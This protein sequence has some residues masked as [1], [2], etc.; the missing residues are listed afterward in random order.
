WY[1]SDPTLV[2]KTQRST[3]VLSDT[4]V[5]PTMEQDYYFSYQRPADNCEIVGKTNVLLTNTLCCQADAG[6]IILPIGYNSGDTLFQGENLQSFT[7]DYSAI[8][9]VNPD[10]TK[11]QYTFL[12]VDSNSTIIQQTMGDFDFTD[13]P[14]GN[15]NVYGLSYANSNTPSNLNNYV[16]LIRNDVD[17]NDITQI[18][19]NENSLA[20]CLAIDGLNESGISKIVIQPLSTQ[21]LPPIPIPDPIPTLNEWGLLILGLLLLNIGILLIKKHIDFQV[22]A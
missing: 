12:L 13:L 22:K 2:S 6:N 11:F 7:V 16:N 17:E 3:I 21:L 20:F 1:N 18:E 10:N 9:E 8:D 14:I 15:Y 4:K 5:S 19:K